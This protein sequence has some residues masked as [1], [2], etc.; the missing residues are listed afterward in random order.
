MTSI[1]SIPL[2]DDIESIRVRFW[3]KVSK[4]SSC[5]V[6][7]ASRMDKLPY[8]RVCAVKGKPVL[9]HRLSY[10]INRGEIPEGMHVLHSCDNPSCVNPDHLFLGTNE[11]NVS[12]KVAKNRQSRMLGEAHPMAKLTDEDVRRIFTSKAKGVTLALTYNVSPNAICRIRKRKTW[13][14]VTADL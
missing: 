3:S 10:A 11:D 4:G 14:H 6:W 9:A 13:V 2:R 1:N 12:D 8:G 5:W 7:T